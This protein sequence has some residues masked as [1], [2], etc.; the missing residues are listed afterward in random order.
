M[1]AK[2]MSIIKSLLSF[3]FPQIL[4]IQ[5]YVMRFGAI[6]SMKIYIALLKRA[7]HINTLLKTNIKVLVLV[8]K[9]H[10]DEKENT[11]RN[12]S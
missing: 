12:I 8:S 9:N 5:N 4:L 1:K 7:I 3:A 10:K 11:N 6:L 2:T